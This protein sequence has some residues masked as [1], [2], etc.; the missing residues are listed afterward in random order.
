MGS[1]IWFF[2]FPCKNTIKKI[3]NKWPIVPSNKSSKSRKKA[4]VSKIVLKKSIIAHNLSIKFWEIYFFSII[5]LL[6]HKIMLVARNSI[7]N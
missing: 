4:I 5:N 1:L 7:L 3:W 2:G 6:F